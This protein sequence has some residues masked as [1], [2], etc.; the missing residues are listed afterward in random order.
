MTVEN[1]PEHVEDLIDL[2]A[3]QHMLIRDLFAE[4]QRASGDARDEAFARLVRLLAV[5]E[6]AEEEV[7]HPLARRSIDGGE[8]VV[9]DRLHEEHQAK[10]ALARLE[11]MDRDSEDFAAAFAKLRAAVLAHAQYEEQYEFRYLRAQHGPDR[12]RTLAKQVRIAEKAAPTHPHPG[13]E[14]APENLAAGPVLAVFDRVK[15]AMR[16]ALSRNG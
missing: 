13:V 15:D 1:R 12:L 8:G 11:S 10:E 9:E 5:H 16:G 14:T 7:V 2:L 6:T 3:G 4:V